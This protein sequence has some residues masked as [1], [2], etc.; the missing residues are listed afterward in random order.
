[1]A[2]VSPG[3]QVTVIDQSNYAPTAIGSVPYLLVA[4]AQDKVAPAALL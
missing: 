4:T 2:L 1:M 3:V